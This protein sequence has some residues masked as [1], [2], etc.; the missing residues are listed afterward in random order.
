M[1]R[2]GMIRPS[3]TGVQPPASGPHASTPMLERKRCASNRA[4]NQQHR[5]RG[6]QSHI[7]GSIPALLEDGRA[8]D[9]TGGNPKPD[10]YLAV[11]GFLAWSLS[12]ACRR[13]NAS[14]KGTVVYS[15]IARITDVLQRPDCRRSGSTC[16]TASTSIA[17]MRTEEAAQRR[18]SRGRPM[19]SFTCSG[20]RSKA[21][22]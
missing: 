17:G 3:V 1:T 21:E 20:A 14:R 19:R 11:C 18:Q 5:A 7:A 2:H 16:R 12:Y 15:R 6:K 9:K 22:E 10:S 4:T 13:P 8:I